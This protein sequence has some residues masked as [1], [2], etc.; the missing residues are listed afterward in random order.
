MGV[1]L[2]LVGR[3]FLASIGLF[4]F[5]ASSPELFTLTTIAGASYIGWLDVQGIR[6]GV[7]RVD[8]AN[9]PMSATH[10]KVFWDAMLIDLLNPKVI[11]VFLALMPNFVKF[12][13]YQVPRQL[14]IL[15]AILIAINTL[16]QLPLA[17][18]ADWIRNLL[19]QPQ[20]QHTVN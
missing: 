5:V 20:P 8:R 1:Q 13:S 18:A 16:C 14:L 15:G 17:L 11:F 2:R 9:V 3:T 7:V 4:I 12:E 19:D 10:T 6:K